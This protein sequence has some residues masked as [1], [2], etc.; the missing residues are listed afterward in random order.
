VLPS[1]EHRCEES[2]AN[3]KLA[4]V[5]D[6][7]P[8]VVPA[9]DFPHDLPDR[10][11]GVE[12]KGTKGF[13]VLSRRWEKVARVAAACAPEPRV[14]AG[15]EKAGQQKRSALDRHPGRVQQTG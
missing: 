6:V 4:A 13:V 14:E 1:V 3:R 2:T 10:I 12:P 11:L 8:L 9:S 15:G 7:R 5:S